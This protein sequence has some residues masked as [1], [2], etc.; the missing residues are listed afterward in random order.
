MGI[1]IVEGRDLVAIDGYVYMRTI[2]GLV[3]VDVIDRRIDDDFIDPSVF[4]KDSVLG[5]PGLIDAYP[6]R[7]RGSGERGRNRRGG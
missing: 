5:V 3:Q 6:S 7:K 2:R 4:R 1:Q